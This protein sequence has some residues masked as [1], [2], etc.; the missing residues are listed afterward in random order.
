MEVSVR[1]AAVLGS[2]VMGSTLAA[3]LANAG[4]PTLLLDIVP[5]AGTGIDGD[6]SAAEYRNA[7]AA[8]GLARALKSK[9]AAF[10]TPAGARMITVGNLDDDLESLRD[11]DWVLEAVVERL[12]IKQSLFEKIL[13]FLS[14]RAIVTTNTS[15]L[16]VTDM[17]GVLPD[18]RRPRFLGTH[19]FNPPR[20]LRLLELIPHDGT[21]PEVLAA[22][23]QIGEERLGK[24]VVIGK[25][26]PSFIANR[27]G[28]F[29]MMALLRAALDGGFTV[30]EV[31]ALTGP[32]I[33]RP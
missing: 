28:G 5:P 19:F 27:V 25:D 23:T 7:F 12:D 2:G 4:I 29:W 17:A 14:D 26:T 8:G 15:G 13:P 20:Y 18:A 6:P 11:V 10:Y 24:G 21:D 22:V 33:G 30:E 9:P 32:V 31:D 16:S 3:H 1:R